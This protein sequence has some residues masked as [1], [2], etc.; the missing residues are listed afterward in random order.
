MHPSVQILCLKKVT[1]AL[2]SDVLR[3][4]VDCEN[5]NRHYPGAESLVL[6]VVGK[7]EDLFSMLVT[8]SA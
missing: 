6:V 1:S 5:L 4:F 7:V 2:Y 3:V 8:F